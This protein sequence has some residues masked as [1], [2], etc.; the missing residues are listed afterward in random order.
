MD[1]K[2]STE[3]R[4]QLH[5]LKALIQLSL[6]VYFPVRSAISFTEISNCFLLGWSYTDYFCLFYKIFNRQFCIVSFYVVSPSHTEENYTFS[7]KFCT[8]YVFKTIFLFFADMEKIF[9]KVTFY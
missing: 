2:L 1:L 8:K 6:I 9:L 4:L 3:K 7:S 5:V